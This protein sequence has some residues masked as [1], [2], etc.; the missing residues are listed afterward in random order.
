MQLEKDQIFRVTK[1]TNANFKGWWSRTRVRYGGWQMAI[2][3]WNY[4][5][6][7][8]PA[9]YDIKVELVKLV[10]LGEIDMD[11]ASNRENPESFLK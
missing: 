11:K 9:Q 2:Q 5:K 8:L 6:Y 4:N 10:T 3:T 7:D 1:T